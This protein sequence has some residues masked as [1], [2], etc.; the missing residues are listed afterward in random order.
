[1]IIKTLL[2]QSLLV[3]SILYLQGCG[4]SYNTVE[5]TPSVVGNINDKDEWY[6][7]QRDYVTKMSVTFDDPNE[8]LCAPYTDPTA[9]PKPCTFEDVNN[10]LDPEDTY[11]PV[12]HINMQTPDYNLT[13]NYNAQISIKG[14]YTRTLSQKS[15]TVKLDKDLP[16]YLTQRKFPLTKSESDRSRLRNKVAFA[17]LRQVPNII[18]LNVNFFHL[19]INGEDYGLFN[20]AEAIREEFLVNRGWNKNDYLYNTVNFT[21]KYDSYFMA[22]NEQG[23]PLY[24]DRFQHVL[25]IKNGKN[26]I[27]LIQ[28]LQAIEA[29]DDIDS[30]IAQYFNRD[31]YLAWLAMNIILGNK[32]T[33]QHNYYLYNPL[34]SD[35]FYFLPWDYDG[36]WS[37][38]KYLKRYEYGIS[39]WWAVPLHRKFLSVKKNREDLYVLI[40]EIRAKY[41]TDK[42]VQTIIDKYLPLVLPYQGVEPDSQNNSESSCAE[43]AQLL[44]TRIQDNIDL[45]KS[46]IG[47]PMPFNENISYDSATKKVSISW[48]ES[49]DLEGDSIV[50]DVNISKESFDN[51]IFSEQN[52]TQYSLETTLPLDPGTYY[53]R[54]MSKEKNNPEHFQYSYSYIK[55]DD[56]IHNGYLEFTVE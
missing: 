22:L 31:N 12:L 5:K 4:S 2:T 11:K 38:P 47:S 56:G 23:E 34:Y 35:T 32:D 7:I 18:G 21:F 51:I 54:V 43:T 25:E 1:M 24:P 52:L 14:N 37:T 29:T 41:V 16:L 26:H 30:V 40:D 48:D 10:D 42:A 17:L 20:Q 55:D 6:T 19:F 39:L 45:F 46:V 49:V 8:Y 53:L 9:E 50:Y 36:A 13:S 3:A 28:M 33:I 27:K 44:V 15:Y